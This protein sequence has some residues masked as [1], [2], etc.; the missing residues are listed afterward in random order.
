MLRAFDELQIEGVPTTIP[1]YRWALE[2]L[3]F[4]EASHTTTWVEQTLDS[5]AVALPPA[6][7]PS[8]RAGAAKPARVV[9]ELDGR[10]V[11]VQVW[12]ED[13]PAPPTPPEAA[14]HGAH[15]HGHDALV[16]PM[17]GTILQVLVE[18]G[19]EVL[20]GDSIIILE[21]MKMENHVA[22]AR[23]G[24]VEK[25]SVKPGD[26]VDPGQVLVSFGE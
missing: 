14:A 16:S 11:P 15:A 4:R 9:V 13:L 26:V 25:V 3:A 12:G 22:A 10:R 24:V 7:E 18:E 5:G 21:A 19:Q 23:D 2:T 1:F 20:A 17:Q 8:A 6:V